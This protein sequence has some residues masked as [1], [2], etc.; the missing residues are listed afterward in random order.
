[1]IFC[2]AFQQ[3]PC[4]DVVACNNEH[5][6]HELDYLACIAAALAAQSEIETGCA[7]TRD[8][9][10]A[11]ASDTFEMDSGTCN[12]TFNG[13]VH[14]D[15]DSCDNVF[16][17]CEDDAEATHATC[18]AAC[19]PGP[20]G[21]ACRKTCDDEQDAADLVCATAQGVCYEGACEIQKSCLETA[22]TAENTAIQDATNG[23][24]DCIEG[25]CSDDETNVVECQNACTVG[26]NSCTNDLTAA[27]NDCLSGCDPECCTLEYIGGDPTLCNNCNLDCE[28]T[29]EETDCQSP[30][31][32]CLWNCVDVDIQ[33]QKPCGS[34]LESGVLDCENDWI[35]AFNGCQS[36]HSIA[37]LMCEKDEGNCNQ[38][39]EVVYA[40]CIGPCGNPGDPGY[41]DC[42]AACNAVRLASEAI[43]A[44]NFTDCE[45]EAEDALEECTTG[46]F[47]DRYECRYIACRD[48]TIFDEDSKCYRDCFFTSGCADCGEIG[49]ISCCSDAMNSCLAECPDVTTVDGVPNLTTCNQCGP[50]G[51]LAFDQTGILS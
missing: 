5:F 37:L 41:D 21:D 1:M 33:K 51:Y 50:F 27:T 7:V 31:Q 15:D 6:A 26:L 43:C 46:P 44:S 22:T 19:S 14:D 4:D 47:A 8:A 45:N 40:D 11:A 38:A 42:I 13:S 34:R 16:S 10:I 49:D 9:I 17:D 20:S 36:A 48:N 39:A 25:A 18:V 12:D 2:A 24:Y 3:T 23:Y 28:I 32:E 35:E 29:E 30:Y